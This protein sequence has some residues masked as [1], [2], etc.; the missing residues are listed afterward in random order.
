MDWFIDGM[1]KKHY[2]WPN[3]KITKTKKEL[4]ENSIMEEARTTAT[5]HEEENFGMITH[6]MK[7]LTN[8]L[9]NTEMALDVFL[10]MMFEKDDA[11]KGQFEDLFKQRMESIRQQYEENEKAQAA[12]Q[13]NEA[14]PEENIDVIVTPT[15]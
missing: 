11:M 4:K 10:G 5:P 7:Y 2:L 13:A 12:A 8:R 6:N 1:M 9:V 14:T 3:I 15:A